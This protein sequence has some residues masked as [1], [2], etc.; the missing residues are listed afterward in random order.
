[1]LPTG[2]GTLSATVS[3]PPGDG[4]SAAEFDAV[5]D[6][7]VSQATIDRWDGSAWVSTGTRIHWR[8]PGDESASPGVE[9]PIGAFESGA[10]RLV[11]DRTDGEPPLAGRFW[12]VR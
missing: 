4:N 8:P 2:G 1:V 10:Y 11:I 3:L 5:V 6:T 9:L 12:V 7:L